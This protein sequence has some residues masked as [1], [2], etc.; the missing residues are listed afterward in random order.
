MICFLWLI[1]PRNF[2]GVY[3][4]FCGPWQIFMGYLFDYSHFPWRYNTFLGI[5]F[6]SFL[7]T[8]TISL[9]LCCFYSGDGSVC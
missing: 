4:T 1:E 9:V 2:M 7:E 3:F 6:F 8:L 5:F